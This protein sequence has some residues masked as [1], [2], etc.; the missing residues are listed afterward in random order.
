[1]AKCHPNFQFDPFNDPKLSLMK[2]YIQTIIHFLTVV[3]LIATITACSSDAPTNNKHELEVI[4]SAHYFS[5][6]WPKTF[7]QEFEEADVLPEL[8]Q[9]KDDGFNTIILTVPWRGFETQFQD[10]TTQ[11]NEFL[12]ERLKFVLTKIQE[13]DLFYML[14]VGFPHDYT[15]DTGTDIATQCKGIYTDEKMQGHWRNYLHK[16]KQ[17]TRNFKQYSVGTIVSW[18]DFWCPHFVFPLL[19]EEKRFKL[20]QQMNYGNWL[21]SN[22]I[23]IVK[24]L[25]KQNQIHFDKI[26]VPQNTELSYILYL[27]FID[28]MLDKNILTSWL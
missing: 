1:M 26:Q 5:S 19:N 9:I 7:W 11:S 6:A 22:K 17:V 12:Y 23:N 28:Y 4:K 20:A 15:P 10:R 2:T 18:E 3:I 16:I 25:F 14:R 8:K 21:K 27:E 24:A 13:S